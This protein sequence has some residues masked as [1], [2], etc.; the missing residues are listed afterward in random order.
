MVTKASV[1]SIFVPRPVTDLGMFG[2]LAH[3]FIN[4]SPK[5]VDIVVILLF[6]TNTISAVLAY[7]LGSKCTRIKCCGCEI[8]RVVDG[9]P[10]EGPEP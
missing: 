8:D 2:V 10:P 5:M 9:A 3:N 4:C 7:L 1:I 6:A